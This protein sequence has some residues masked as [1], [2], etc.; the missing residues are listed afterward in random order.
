MTKLSDG[1]DSYDGWHARTPCNASEAQ[2]YEMR[3][4]A[5]KHGLTTAQAVDLLR[6]IGKDRGK[7][8]E[9]AARLR[10]SQGN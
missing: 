6:R 7:L 5:R 1:R 2:G 8:N 3:Y 10:R 4:F 9:A